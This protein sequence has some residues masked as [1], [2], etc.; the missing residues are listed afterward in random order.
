MPDF[1]RNPYALFVPPLIL[2]HL[3]SALVCAVQLSWLLGNVR[4]QVCQMGAN[5]T[6]ETGWMTSVII[7]KMCSLHISDEK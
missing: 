3:H 4:Q 7:E 6:N 5:E 2:S 1:S